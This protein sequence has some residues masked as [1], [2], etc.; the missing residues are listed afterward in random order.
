MID[1]FVFNALNDSATGGPTRDVISDFASGVDDISLTAIDANTA[2][3]GNQ[4]FSFNGAT[5]KAYAVWYVDIGTDL[6]VQGDVN[7]DTV[8]DFEIQV[9]GIDS[10]TAGDFIL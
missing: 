3:A 7:G 6:V 2:L 10:I 1:V 5:A 8:A 9:A 4:A